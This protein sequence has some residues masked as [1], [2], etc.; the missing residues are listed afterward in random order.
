MNIVELIRTI[1]ERPAMYIGKHSIFCLRA[2]MDGWY[3]RNPNEDVQMQLLNDFTLWLQNSFFN[4]K[5]YSCSWCEFIYW[6]SYN[7][8]N[9]ALDKFFILFEQYLIEE[10]DNKQLNC[11]EK[12]G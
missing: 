9:K 8:E 7:D 12:V 5:E 2:F 6:M 11:P 1:K 10:T 4:G 3:F